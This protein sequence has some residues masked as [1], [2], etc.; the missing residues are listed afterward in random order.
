M[1]ML[2]SSSTTGASG[3]CISKESEEPSGVSVS[4]VDTVTS[5]TPS[6]GVTT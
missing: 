5:S 1:F 2:N 6:E 4:V 3:V